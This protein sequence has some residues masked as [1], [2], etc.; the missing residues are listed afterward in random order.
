MKQS[1][2][3]RKEL[4]AQGWKFSVVIGCIITF[5]KGDSFLIWD[6]DKQLVVVQY[7]Y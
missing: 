3:T 1:R 7:D 5:N 6:M 4:E 2:V